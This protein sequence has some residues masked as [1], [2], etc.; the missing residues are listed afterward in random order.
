MLE[1]VILRKFRSSSGIAAVTQ[2]FRISDHDDD[3][4]TGK[5]DRAGEVRLLQDLLENSH[6]TFYRSALWHNGISQ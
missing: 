4:V 3:E 6:E 1:S 2:W 5:M